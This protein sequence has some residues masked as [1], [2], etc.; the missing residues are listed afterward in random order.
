M[1]KKITRE[2]RQICSEMEASKREDSEPKE[3][4]R[5]F[6]RDEANECV[7]KVKNRETAGVDEI[8]NEFQKCGGEGMITMMIIQYNWI[9]ENEYTPMRWI[10]EVVVNHLK[11]VRLL[12][13]E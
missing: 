9:W 11:C 1:K 13:I 2:Q 10:E 12:K 3:F 5:E 6:T 4:R 8:V 7:D